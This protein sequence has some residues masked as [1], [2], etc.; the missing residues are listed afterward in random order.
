MTT[1]DAP[2]ASSSESPSRK[3]GSGLIQS[4]GVTLH[5][6]VGASSCISWENNWRVLEGEQLALRSGLEGYRG[7]LSG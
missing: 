1:I 5:R 4:S 7:L 2:S 6:V 3:E